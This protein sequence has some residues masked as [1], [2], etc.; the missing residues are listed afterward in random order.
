MLQLEF[1]LLQVGTDTWRWDL[2]HDGLFSVK[3]ARVIIDRK[4]LM[5]VDVH[6]RWCKLIPKKVNVFLWR[7]VHDRLLTRWL[8]GIR[9]I[10]LDHIMCPVCD[11]APE[12]IHH[13]FADVRWLWLCR[14]RWVDAAKFRFLRL[15]WSMTFGH[16][17]T[18]RMGLRIARRC[19]MFWLGRYFG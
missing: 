13:L 14:R 15:W 16:G 12:Q 8:L 9:G 11:G 18:C 5:A 6:V 1:V 17:L 4:S 2:G 7:L 19:W 3:E 10:P